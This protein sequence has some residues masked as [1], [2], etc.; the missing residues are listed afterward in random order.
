MKIV[1][2]KKKENSNHEIV[3]ESS[4]LSYTNHENLNQCKIFRFG[5]ITITQ[6]FQ[7]CYAY[8]TKCV[9]KFL[10]SLKFLLQTQS[11]DPHHLCRI[12]MHLKL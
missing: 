3:C 1:T 2:L 8:A 11:N 12:R 4:E 10:F 7:L 6:Q 9:W 5:C